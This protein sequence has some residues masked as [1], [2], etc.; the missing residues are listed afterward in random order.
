MVERIDYLADTLVGIIDILGDRIVGPIDTIRDR[1]GSV[2]SVIEERPVAQQHIG[3]RFTT[4]VAGGAVGSR[5]GHR[6]R[7]QGIGEASETMGAV[8]AVGGYGS[9][10]IGELDLI[11]QPV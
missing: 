9:A 7:T 1:G 4:D 11:A 6:G 3:A 2:E 5:I 8:I 10:R